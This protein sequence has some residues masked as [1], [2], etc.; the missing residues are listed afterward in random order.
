MRFTVLGSGTTLSSMA[1]RGP[2]GFLVRHDGRAWLVDGGSGT[3]QRCARAGVDPV[4]LDG[5]V[6]SHRHIDHCAD[7]AP[8]LFSMFVADRDRDYPIWAGVG[9]QDYLDQLSALYEGWFRFKKQYGPAVTELTLEG[10]GEADLGG[11]L[12]RT[13]PANHDLGAMHLRFEAGGQAVVFSGDTGPSPAL[14]ELARG[15][16]LLVCECALPEDSKYTSHLRASEVAAIVREARPKEVWLTH[17]YPDVDPEEALATVA[18]T[19]VKTR[20]AADGDTWQSA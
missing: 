18:A 10:P 5:G 4:T 12:L 17:L 15:A 19:G 2:A 11:V 8:L 20:L 14:A 1:D 3:M 16:D 9:F 6:Y 7:L 13:R